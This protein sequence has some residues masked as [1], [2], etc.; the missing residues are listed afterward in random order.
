MIR[1]QHICAQ[2]RR[3]PFHSSI[4]RRLS[5]PAEPGGNTTL[6]IAGLSYAGRFD[7]SVVRIFGTANGP[8]LSSR[9]SQELANSKVTESWLLS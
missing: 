9:V 3:H 7:I 2:L 5:T 8:P 6:G 1:C 4:R